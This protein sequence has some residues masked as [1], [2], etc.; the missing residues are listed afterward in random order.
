MSG[1]AATPGRRS[2]RSWPIRRCAA[3]PGPPI[4]RRRRGRG[5]RRGCG[6]G[7]G[8]HRRGNCDRTHRRHACY[9]QAA[10][11][12]VTAPA[13]G[14]FD[15]DQPE[16]VGDR[17]AVRGRDCVPD[18]T[19]GSEL[20]E[21]RYRLGGGEGQVVGGDFPTRSWWPG[22]VRRARHGSVRGRLLRTGRARPRL[23]PTS[24]PARP[25]GSSRRP[26]RRQSGGSSRPRPLRSPRPTAPK[27]PPPTARTGEGTQRTGPSG[28]E[29][30]GGYPSPASDLSASPGV[31]RQRGRPRDRHPP[32]GDR[33]GQLDQD[34]LETRAARPGRGNTIRIDP[35]LPGGPGS[36]G[37]PVVERSMPA[38]LDD[39]AGIDRPRPRLVAQ[40]EVAGGDEIGLGRFQ[41]L[42]GKPGLLP[43]SDDRRQPRH[44]PGDRR[45]V[46]PPVAGP[47]AQGRKGPRRQD[48]DRRPR[49]Q[50]RQ[51]KRNRPGAGP[52]PRHEQRGGRR[53][54]PLVW[55]VRPEEPTGGE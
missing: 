14:R 52:W 31:P 15:G 26:R 33:L 12:A 25:E 55:P 22:H 42:T 46:R 54:P 18:G 8:S 1:G 5:C 7:A 3:R 39:P 32:R 40:C 45:G 44:Q 16:R 23:P 35:N 41:I 10:G 30:L 37:A 13:P 36:L 24:V 50:P 34:R 29:S 2:R 17:L 6:C 38:G 53:G 19:V 49:P 48:Q 11:A 28:P 9:F 4:G 20:G 21:H 51:A 43:A 27:P 47:A